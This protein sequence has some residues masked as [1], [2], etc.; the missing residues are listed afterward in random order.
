MDVQKA[1]QVLVNF[2]GDGVVDD[3]GVFAYGSSRWTPK[4][5]GGAIFAQVASLLTTM[6]KDPSQFD[7]QLYTLAVHTTTNPQDVTAFANQLLIV[8]NRNGL[9][10][11]HDA[12]LVQRNPFVCAVELVS[13][14]D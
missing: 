9:G 11:P 5:G 2:F 7:S 6:G 14:G 4:D 12:A 1:G 8:N 10:R 13:S 3:N